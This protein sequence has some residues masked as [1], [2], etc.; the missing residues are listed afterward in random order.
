MEIRSCEPIYYVSIFTCY[1]AR[2]RGKNCLFMRRLA[3]SMVHADDGS[4]MS[5]YYYSS[6]CFFERIDGFFK[7]IR[8]LNIRSAFFYPLPS[9]RE[10]SLPSPKIKSFRDSDSKTGLKRFTCCAKNARYVGRHISKYRN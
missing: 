1:C 9:S 10:P 4:K 3:H 5:F 8:R 2:K 6:V 7:F